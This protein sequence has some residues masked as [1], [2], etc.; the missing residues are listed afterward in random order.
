MLTMLLVALAVVIL[1]GL[2]VRRAALRRRHAQ[3]LARSAVV[4]RQRLL[5]RY[6]GRR[7]PQT[8]VRLPRC[9]VC[10]EVFADMDEL[11]DHMR[12]H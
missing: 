9:P 6:V 4:R 12:D 1:T 3:E 7:S 8:P 5:M 2:T 11:R 10:R